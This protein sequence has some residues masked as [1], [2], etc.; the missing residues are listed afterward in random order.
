MIRGMSFLTDLTLRRREPELMDDPALDARQHFAALRGLERINR[1]SGS[2]RIVWSAIA[3]LPPG[4]GAH[5]LRVLDVATGAGDVP[6][7][8]CVRA[9]QAGR[10]LQIDAADVSPT[11]LEFARQRAARA[12]VPA[13]AAGAGVGVRF[14][15]LDAL[16]D[17]LPDGYDVITSSLFLHHLAGEDAATLLAKMAAARPRLIVVNDL[18]RDWL[19]YALAFLGPR[20]LTRCRVVHVDAVRSVRAAFTMQEVRNLAGQAGLRNF[21][22]QHR[23]PRRFLL[24]WQP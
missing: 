5:P 24:T 1:W 13:V 19:G 16:H 12:G 10:M 21:V 6:I 11:A 3:A 7:G 18:L 8:L 14:L 9:A 23:W 2:V 20:V 15:T 22:L 17:A 4:P